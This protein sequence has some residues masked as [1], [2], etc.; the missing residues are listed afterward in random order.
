MKQIILLTFLL[1]SSVVW[2]DL[3]KAVEFTE[4][5]KYKEAK[6]ELLEIVRTARAGGAKSQFE[7]GTMKSEGFWQIQDNK[8]AIEWWKKSANQGYVQ[9][10]IMMGSVYLGGVKAE[11]DL[12]KANYWFDKAIELDGEIVTLVDALKALAIEQENRVKK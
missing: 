1:L 11:K 10:Q 3:D 5:G 2:A 4:Q 8:K 9:A 7:L 6:S 12:K